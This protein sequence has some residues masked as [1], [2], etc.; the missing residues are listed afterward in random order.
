MLHFCCQD[1]RKKPQKIC[2]K[3]KNCLVSRDISTMHIEFPRLIY[4]DA[5]F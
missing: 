4:L 2:V 3:N 1:K 5:S